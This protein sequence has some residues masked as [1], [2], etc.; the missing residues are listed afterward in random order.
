MK[1]L[2]VQRPSNNDKAI[3]INERVSTE[4]ERLPDLDAS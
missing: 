4:P 3:Y 2:E 1:D